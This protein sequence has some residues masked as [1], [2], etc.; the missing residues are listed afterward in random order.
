MRSCYLGSTAHLNSLNL[1]S[2]LLLPKVVPK[3]QSWEPDLVLFITIF[4]LSKPK[5]R[6]VYLATACNEG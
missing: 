5:G 4:R 1:G 2:Q 6:L 3:S